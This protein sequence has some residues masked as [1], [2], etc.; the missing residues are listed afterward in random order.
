M[1]LHYLGNHELRKWVFLVMLKNDTAL[2][3]YIFNTHRPILIIFCIYCI[4]SHGSKTAKKIIKRWYYSSLRWHLDDVMVGWVVSSFYD[5]CSFWSMAVNAI[6][7]LQF[8]IIYL[9]F[10]K[11]TKVSVTFV[12]AAVVVLW[13]LPYPACQLSSQRDLAYHVQRNAVTH[14]S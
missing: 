2:V 9:Y 7:K 5:F 11:C 1:S 3:C 6:D 8:F 4:N 10:I 13:S 12:A 14:H